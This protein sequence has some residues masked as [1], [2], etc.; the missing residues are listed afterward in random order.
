MY[1]PPNVLGTDSKY[2]HKVKGTKEDAICSNRGL[3]DVTTGICICEPGFDSSDGYNNPG[4]RV[5]SCI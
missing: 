3:C 2:K 1:S 5:G 4:P